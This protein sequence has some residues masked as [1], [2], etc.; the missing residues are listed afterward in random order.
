MLRRFGKSTIVIL[1]LVLIAGCAYNNYRPT[2]DGEPLQLIWG[3]VAAP[4]APWFISKRPYV[5][6]ES[7][8]VVYD[9]MT[10]Y[11]KFDYYFGRLLTAGIGPIGTN[12]EDAPMSG[13]EA[14]LILSKTWTLESDFSRQALDEVRQ[15]LVD[16]YKRKGMAVT[17]V[18]DISKEYA[19]KM[20]FWTG[21]MFAL[22]YKAA[23]VD[24]RVVHAFALHTSRTPNV[25]IVNDFSYIRM[26]KADSQD[27][28]GDFINMLK[29]VRE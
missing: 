15:R 6:K 22:A 29:T 24:Y 20:K 8:L 9:L 5:S 2:R 18:K 1:T 26:E 10:G 19:D 13:N 16:T 23:G 3:G 27:H 28:F 21:S 11:S 14:I 4:G 7:R 25:Q 12:P 17:D